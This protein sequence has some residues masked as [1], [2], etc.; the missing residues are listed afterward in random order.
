[1]SHPPPAAGVTQWSGQPAR[2]PARSPRRLSQQQGARGG[3]PRRERGQERPQAAASPHAARQRGLRPPEPEIGGLCSPA[4][5]PDSPAGRPT[6]RGMERAASGPRSAGTSRTC[7][8]NR[9]ARVAGK[10]RRARPLGVPA[11]PRR[12]PLLSPEGRVPTAPDARPVHAPATSADLIAQQ[13]RVGAWGQ[14]PDST[15]LAERSS[16]PRRSPGSESP[17]RASSFPGAR[18]LPFPC[19][20]LAGRRGTLLAGAA[21]RVA[22]PARAGGFSA[23]PASDGADPGRGERPEALKAP[24]RESRG[25]SFAEGSGGWEPGRGSGESGPTRA[26]AVVATRENLGLH[27]GALNLCLGGKLFAWKFSSRVEECLCGK[28]RLD[29]KR[30]VR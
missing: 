10:L 18:P 25:Q 8:W 29:L 13:C 23:A 14:D 27:P 9:E 16:D 4:R 21:G 12:P 28:K 26:T 7:S 15:R 1:M 20:P 17:T 24:Q 11:K 6:G 30:V 3:G 2:P 5:D 19:S 22:R